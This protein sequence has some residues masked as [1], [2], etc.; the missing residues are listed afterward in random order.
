MTLP[1]YPRYTQNFL[2][3]TAGWPLELKGAYGILL[4]LIY[5]HGGQLP[6][7]PQFIAGNLG[8]SVRKWNAIRDALLAKGKII[9]GLSQDNLKI[10]SNKRAEKEAEKLRRY[11]EKQRKNGA[12]AHENKNLSDAT[13][14]ALGVAVGDAKGEPAHQPV[15]ASL[16]LD[17]DKKEEEGAGAREAF[18][19]DQACSPKPPCDRPPAIPPGLLDDLR[20]AVGIQTHDAG[21]YWSNPTLRGYVEAWIAAGLTPDRIVAEA[22]AS[23]A[24]NPEPPDGPK[25]L[26]RWMQAAAKGIPDPARPQGQRAQVKPPASPE[27]RLKF[28]GDWVNGEKPLP[29][30]AISTSMAQALLNAKL[31]TMSRLRERGIAA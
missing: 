23:R 2:E 7:D 13:A 19:E 31:V 1:Y 3:A 27:E 5:H 6:D 17:S 11:E 24:K 26:E 4:D 20:Q 16:D 22:K 14:D 25:A 21:P 9:S 29:P 15:R 18:S 28:F 8:C 30:S 12:K 10:I